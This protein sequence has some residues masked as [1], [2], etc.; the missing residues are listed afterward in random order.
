MYR[1]FETIEYA[2]EVLESLGGREKLQ[3]EHY[4]QAGLNPLL[5]EKEDEI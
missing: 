2:K 3:K 4:K 5:P 1:D